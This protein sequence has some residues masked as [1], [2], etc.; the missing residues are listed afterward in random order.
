MAQ[1]PARIIHLIASSGL[2]GA[3]RVVANLSGTSGAD[4]HVACLCRTPD[5]VANFRESV[6]G[7]GATFHAL[8]VSLLAA[9][10]S[11]QSLLSTQAVILNAHGYKE[12]VLALMCIFLCRISGKQAAMLVTQHGFTARNRKSQIYNFINKAI[13]RFGPVS[14]VIC[15]SASILE[16]YRQFGVPEKRLR[17][18]TNGVPRA[19]LID[20]VSARSQMAFTTGADA[21]IPWI[22][23]AGRLSEEKNPALM[24]SLCQQLLQQDFPCGVFLAGDGPLK[25]ALEAQI[26]ADKLTGQVFLTGFTSDM[27]AFLGAMDVLVVPSFTEG[28]PMIV[29]EA[30][31][32]GIPVVAAKVGGLPDI[33]T[34]DCDGI[35]VEGHDAGRY[36]SSVKAL[37]EAPAQQGE[38]G[39]KAKATIE[40]RYSVDAQ[41][42]ACQQLY[43]EALSCVGV[44]QP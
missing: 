20:K 40:A 24:V 44:S 29:L 35:L 42:R 5:V 23:Y 21:N 9:L 30:M 26:H 37:L 17:L 13:C 2:Y 4:T 27:P 8:P 22:G 7:Q 12:A 36:A 32:M 10:R 11:L 31:S 34:S 1:E 6:I 33:I 25:A 28:T 3:E 39:K 14:S 38:I 18:I 41:G 43:D 19:Q 16:I 15:V